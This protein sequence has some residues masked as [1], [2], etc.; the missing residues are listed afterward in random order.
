M[1][2]K[3]RWHDVY[4]CC[5]IQVYFYHQYCNLV[6][7]L[8]LKVHV[9]QHFMNMDFSLVFVVVYNR[10]V[11]LHIYMCYAQYVSKSVTKCLIES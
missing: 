5:S 7:I 9:Y 8:L 4:H 10:N 3:I 2:T 11:Y 1:H 6:H